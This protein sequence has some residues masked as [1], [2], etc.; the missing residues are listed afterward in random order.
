LIAI[1]LTMIFTDLASSAEAIAR[2]VSRWQGF[3]QA[4]SRYPVFEIMLVF[5][6]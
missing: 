3:A 5:C 2:E 1:F 4:G 6:A